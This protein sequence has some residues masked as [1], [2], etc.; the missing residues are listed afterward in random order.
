MTAPRHPTSSADSARDGELA[1]RIQATG[2]DAAAEAE[3]CRRLLPRVRAFA[4]RHLRDREG[5]QDLTQHVL[6]ALVARLRQGALLDPEQVGAFALGIA[7][8][9]AREFVRADARWRQHHAAADVDEAIAPAPAPPD[10]EDLEHCVEGL[11]ERERTVVLLTFHD[12]LGAAPIA[13]QLGTT[14]GN[15]RV[16]RARAL[17]RLRDCLET[18]ARREDA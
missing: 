11:A 2:T 4:G 7:R 3:L 16:I 15:V 5:R 8:N 9:A 17:Q 13:D 14:D 10:T 12:R 18:M 6:A 1:R